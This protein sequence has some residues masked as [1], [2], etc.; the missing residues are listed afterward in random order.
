MN[1]Y[2]KIN[3]VMKKVGVIGKN[4]VNQQQGYAFRG[5]DDMLNSFYPALCEVGI[6]IVPRVK[7]ETHELKDVVRT[8]GRST[9]D[10][11]VSLLVEFD[12][13]ST[14]GTSIT[15]GPIA[16]EGID[17]GDK[18]TNKALSGAL[19]YALIQTFSIPT[20]DMV[21]QDLESPVIE[22]SKPVDAPVNKFRRNTP[23][24]QPAVDE[25]GF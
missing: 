24:P 11:H 21:D 3:E 18:A 4:R 2:Q 1:I 9:I 5:I 13:V 10:K 16:S 7:S 19:K 22:S 8:N 6:F 20:A 23:K 14:D 25:D 17:S 15:I 12:L